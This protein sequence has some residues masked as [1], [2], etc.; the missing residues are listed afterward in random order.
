MLEKVHRGAIVAA[1]PEREDFSAGIRTVVHLGLYFEELKQQ[2]LELVARIPAQERGYFTPAEEDEAR[3]LLVSFWHSRGALLDLVTGYRRSAPAGKADQ[4]AAFLVALA[5]ALVLL[6]AARFFHDLLRHRPVVRRKL[7]EP[8]T[9]YGIP[10]GTYDAIQRSLVSTRHAWNLRYAA[11]YFEENEA[12]LRELALD[13]DLAPVMA[14]IDRHRNRLD[15]TFTQFAR[16]KIRVRGGQLLRSLARGI[17]GRALYGLQRLGASMMARVSVRP[18]HVPRMP[19]AAAEQL[20]SHLQIG[21]VIVS[22]KEYA[23]TNF[24]LPG[25]WP[26]AALY[27][28]DV[29]AIERL[30]IGPHKAGAARWQRLVKSG[31]PEGL[32]LEPKR[33]GVRFRS[34]RTTLASDSVL[35]LRPNLGSGELS[36]AVARAIAHE[37]KPYDFD[38]DFTRSDRLVCTELIYRSFDGVGPM[39]IDLTRR[40][41]RPTLCGSDLVR[42]SLARS[43]FS[44]VIAYAPAFSDRLLAGPELDGVLRLAGDIAHAR[45]VMPVSA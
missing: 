4:P 6:D 10:G 45:M 8:S 41:G 38:F 29:A 40:L 39:R 9:H 42:M 11:R 21:D 26:H 12:S 25:Y 17:F 23:I 13:G 16:E 20:R 22:R 32:V 7:N 31:C 28:G 37:G 1:L 34:L 14:I 36:Q 3:A 30:G 44:P 33:D 35:V 24:F 18:G 2:A 27:L 5:A 15:M 43:N 19:D